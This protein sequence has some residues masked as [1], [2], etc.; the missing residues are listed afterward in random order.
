[1][2][3]EI[4]GYDLIG[5]KISPT[6]REHIFINDDSNKT[7][8]ANNPSHVVKGTRKTKKLKYSLWS[9]QDYRRLQN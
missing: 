3:Y 5:Y 1:M 7:V 4:L 9:T 2:K 8:F 6:E